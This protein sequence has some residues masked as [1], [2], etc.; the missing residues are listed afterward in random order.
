[1]RQ[2]EANNKE[3]LDEIV[4]R[5]YKTLKDFGGVLEANPH[6]QDKSFLSDGDIV[7]LPIFEKE[8]KTEV[9]GLW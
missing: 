4:Y 6:L 8:V 3:R 1:M 5:E 9:S 2:I 7:Y